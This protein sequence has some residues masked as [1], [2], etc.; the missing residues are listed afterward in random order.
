M[1]CTKKEG[2]EKE[3]LVDNRNNI[4]VKQSQITFILKELADTI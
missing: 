4:Q 2:G 3:L 1:H